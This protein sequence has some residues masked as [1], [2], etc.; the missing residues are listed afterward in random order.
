MSTD[1]PADRS[2]PIVAQLSSLFRSEGGPQIGKCVI[3]GEQ[4]LPSLSATSQHWRLCFGALSSYLV[5]SIVLMS[6]SCGLGKWRREEP[7]VRGSDNVNPHLLSR[8]YDS[9]TLNVS[10]SHTS[11]D[12]SRSALT[13][14]TS[15][16]AVSFPCN[17]LPLYDLR[18]QCRRTCWLSLAKA[19]ALRRGPAN[20][21]KHSYKQT[22]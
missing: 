5:S 12:Y 7:L 13:L 10:E 16:R 19:L 9:E 3:V 15:R 17:H 20:P 22:H 6:C 1:L 18:I 21:R 4:D 11:P 8:R 14:T 2:Q